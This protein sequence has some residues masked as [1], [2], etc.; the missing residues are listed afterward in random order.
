[1][2]TGPLPAASMRGITARHTPALQST[3]CSNST[4]ALAGRAGGSRIAHHSN[5]MRGCDF[6][7]AQASPTKSRTVS[8]A[9][10]LHSGGR[11]V[12]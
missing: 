5:A 3:P 12:R 8:R 2:Y 6:A 4:G 11:R 10:I 9:P 7:I 1:M